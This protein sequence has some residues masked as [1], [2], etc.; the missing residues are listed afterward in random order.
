MIL[1]LT[2]QKG[3]VGKTTLSVHIAAALAMRGRRVRLIDMDPQHSALDWQAARDN[4]QLAPLFEI[5]G[6]PKETLHKHIES[7]AKGFDD[8]ILDVPPQTAALARSAI[9]SADI[10]LIPVQ[11]SPYDVWA[12]KETVGLWE[13]ARVFKPGLRALF[14]LNRH[15]V[16]TAIGRDVREAL[17]H[18]EEVPVMEAV[19][20]QRVIF[21]ESAASGQVAMEIDADSAASREVLSLCDELLA[22]FAQ[23]KED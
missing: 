17:G 16:G 8:V 22:R 7:K 5:D 4:T 11:P 18:Y 19:I 3:G 12:A 20:A 6:Y 9:L 2:N 21:A 1:A 23:K 14:A 15:I 13:E 10:I